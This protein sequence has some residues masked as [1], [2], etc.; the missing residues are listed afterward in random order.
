[1]PPWIWMFSAATWKKVS[2]AYAF[3]SGAMTGTSAEPSATAAAA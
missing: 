2:E 3:T 1:M